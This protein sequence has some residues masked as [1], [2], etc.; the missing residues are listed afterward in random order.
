[1]RETADPIVVRPAA[2]ADAEAL[3]ALGARTFAETF[4]ADNGPEDMA[5]Y[6]AESFSPALQEAEIADPAGLVLVAAEAG[7]GGARPGA[8]HGYAHLTFGEGDAAFL[9]RLYVLASAKGRGLGR[10]LADRAA[11]EAA[12]RGYASLRLGVWERNAP[13]IAFYHRLGFHRTGTTTFRL[14]EDLQTDW[15]MEKVLERG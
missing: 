15:V 14:G 11:T 4:A 8:L 13:A 6:L 2:R 10:A 1:M 7:P 9:K 5:R 12:R 3:A